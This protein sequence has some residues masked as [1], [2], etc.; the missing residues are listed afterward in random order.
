MVMLL[1]GAHS[2]S[3]VFKTWAL[4]NLPK[5]KSIGFKDEEEMGERGRDSSRT[6]RNW[7]QSERQPGCRREA[8]AEG[9]YPMGT[10]MDVWGSQAG[11]ISIA[12]PALL[13]TTKSRIYFRNHKERHIHLQNSLQ[14]W[15]AHGVTDLYNEG[16]MHFLLVR[17]GDLLKHVNVAKEGNILVTRTRQ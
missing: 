1:N 16:R 8:G 12:C 3:K 7:K 15:S 11:P 4:G 2:F 13:P 6:K 5:E 14:I 9:Q 10:Y 17:V